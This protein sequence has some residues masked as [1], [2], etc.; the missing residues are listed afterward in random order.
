MNDKIIRITTPDRY[1]SFKEMKSFFSSDV[2]HTFNID[3][4][5]TQDDLIK[6]HDII[7]DFCITIGKNPTEFIKEYT[8]TLLT[9][10][11]KD[12]AITIDGFIETSNNLDFPDEVVDKIKSIKKVK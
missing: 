3:M 9:T 8:T 7:Y 12:S 11:L 4:N 2:L 5:V 10:C 1:I 6:I